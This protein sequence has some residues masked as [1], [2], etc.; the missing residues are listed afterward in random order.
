MGRPQSSSTAVKG[1]VPH[2][3]TT[4]MTHHSKFSKPNDRPNTAKPQ[5]IGS[6]FYRNHK[7]GITETPMAL[8]RSSSQDMQENNEQLM[9]RAQ[10]LKEISSMLNKRMMR[11]SARGRL[12]GSATNKTYNKSMGGGRIQSGHHVT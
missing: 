3:S 7:P 5:R 1:V 12:T 2:V 4:G 6:S 11:R 8:A 9:Q 10:S